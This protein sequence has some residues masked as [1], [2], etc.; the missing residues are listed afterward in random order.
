MRMQR[1]AR[2]LSGQAGFTLIEALIAS[3]VFLIVLYGVYTV[4]DVGEANYSK[5][6]RRWDVQTEARIAL[7]RMAREIRA[8]GYASP[9]LSDPVVIA[10]NDTLSI[11]ANMDGTGAKYITYSLRDCSGNVGT[12]LY[13]NVSTTTY[14]GGDPFIDNVAGLTF[15]YYEL[16]NLTLPYP[17]T[18]TYQLDGQDAV[19]GTTVP[20]APAV[21]SDRSLIKQIKISLNV[22]Q[23]V[24]G[25][26][27]PFTATTDVAL[28]NLIP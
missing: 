3:S 11:H 13:R 23:Q 26:T 2:R 6:S 28:R 25:V 19:T 22:Q 18:S 1:Q 14:C 21:G 20:S 12:T 16:N 17:L 4:Y 27:I 5:G 10:T 15:T 24:R 8:A 9:K 7:E